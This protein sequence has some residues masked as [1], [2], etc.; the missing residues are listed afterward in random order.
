[1]EKKY[2]KVLHAS[3]AGYFALSGSDNVPCLIYVT[4]SNRIM[5]YHNIRFRD[6]GCSNLLETMREQE[7]VQDLLNY[8][9]VDGMHYTFIYFLRVLLHEILLYF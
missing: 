6:V 3:I 5:V 8:F 9:N 4:F 7:G 2:L 1:M